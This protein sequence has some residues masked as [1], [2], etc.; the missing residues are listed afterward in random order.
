MSG[1][2]ED[3]VW[4]LEKLWAGKWGSR[5]WELLGICWRGLEEIVGCELK[6]WAGI[7]KKNKG[8]FHEALQGWAGKGNEGRHQHGHDLVKEGRGL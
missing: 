7:K 4:G 2:L 6:L 3:L 1:D 8:S 5:D